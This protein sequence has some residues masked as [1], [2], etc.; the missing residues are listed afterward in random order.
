MDSNEKYEL[1]LTQLRAKEG[2][3]CDMDGVIYHGNNLLPGVREFVNWLY[4]EK[5][6]FLFLT[7]ASE[8]SPKE[9]QQKLLRL[10]LEVD[11]SHFYTSAL[12]TAKF[13]HSQAPGCSAYVIGG[14]GL[15]NAIYDAGITMNDVNPDYVV[16][17][18]GRSYS[19]DTLTKATNLVMAGAKLI[20]ANSDVSGPIEDGIAPACRA[21]VAPIEMATGKQA[22]FCGKPN[23]LMMRTGLRMLQCHS[24]EAVMVGDRMDTD[25]I[26]GLESGMSTVLVL[27]GVST[28]ETLNTYAYRPSIVLDGVG[29]IPKM[30]K[31]QKTSS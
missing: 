22:Y 29:D 30:A 31:A 20:G 19:L 17:G 24:A 11:E 4:E 21:L 15:V 6:S 5:K 14:P 1:L 7:N 16:V 12:A 26:S 3:I 13:I 2:F 8:R 28:R 10:G 23:P 9:L 25:V 18:E 27:S